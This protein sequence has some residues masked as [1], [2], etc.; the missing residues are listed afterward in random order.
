[1]RAA[2]PLNARIDFLKIRAL[3]G[4]GRKTWVCRLGDFSLAILFICLLMK[5]YFGCRFLMDENEWKG[6]RKNDPDAARTE[7]RSYASYHAICYA[8]CM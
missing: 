2:T 7:L 5:I 3:W 4:P 8:C 1:M 6:S